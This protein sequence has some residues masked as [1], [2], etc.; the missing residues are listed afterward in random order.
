M[1]TYMHS[2]RHAFTMHACTYTCF[3]CMYICMDACMH[4]STQYACIHPSMEGERWWCV[5]VCGERN[6]R[7]SKSTTPDWGCTE[8]WTYNGRNSAS[9]GTWP[10][11]LPLE[12]R[13]HKIFP[14]TRPAAKALGPDSQ[15]D[16]RTWKSW[17]SFL[18]WIPRN[19]HACVICMSYACVLR[20]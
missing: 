7:A 16:L 2:N 15:L 9:H 6:A 3:E 12:R 14:C 18:F 4:L 13:P 11:K 1:Q 20:T 10:P 5:F 17:K 19:K 8:P